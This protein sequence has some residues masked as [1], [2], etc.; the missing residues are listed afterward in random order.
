MFKVVMPKLFKGEL[1]GHVESF[2]VRSFLSFMTLA[3]YTS[4]G[5]APTVTDVGGA[6]EGRVGVAGTRN[7]AN[8]K[9]P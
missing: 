5:A 7:A 4:G 6:G 1:T 2:F 3:K 8:G 9:S